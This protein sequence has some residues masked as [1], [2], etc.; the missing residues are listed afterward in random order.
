MSWYLLYSATIPHVLIISLLF[1]WVSPYI[2]P[3]FPWKMSQ[4][5]YF[6]LSMFAS[7]NDMQDKSY[8]WHCVYCL[9]KDKVQYHP[10]AIVTNHNTLLIC[11]SRSCT[12]YLTDVSEVVIPYIVRNSICM[13]CICVDLCHR[14]ESL[15]QFGLLLCYTFCKSFGNNTLNC[16]CFRHGFKF[17]PFK[18]T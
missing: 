3:C 9:V 4:E 16:F 5:N 8:V 7:G 18:Y 14:N 12:S 13:S 17:T 10:T 6:Q 1:L 15:C 2:L 11:V